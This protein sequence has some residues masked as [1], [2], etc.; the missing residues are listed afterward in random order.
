MSEVEI[1]R[2]KRARRAY[3]LDDIAVVPSRRTRDVQEVTTSWQLDAY[4]L[5]I[6]V[7]SAPMDSVTSPETAIEIGR[8]GGVGVLDLEGLWTR[9][10]DPRP[11]F[12]EIADLDQRSSIARL[13]EI[14]AEPVKEELIT[15]RLNEIRDAGVTVAGALSPGRT[16]E[17]WRT[18]VD[19]GVDIFVIRGTTVSAE[20]VSANRE[21]LNLKRFIYELDVPVLVG[22]A[23]TYTGALHLMR[24]G[25]AGVL[26]GY[27]GGAASANRRTVGIA[28]PMATTIA[29]I[30]A[31]RRDYL[32]ESGGRY[33]HV[34]ADGSV[35]TA[36]DVVKAIACGADGV[37][38]GTA[39]ARADEAPGRGWHWGQEAH[40][41]RLPRG[42]RVQVGTAGPLEQI[43][44]GPSHTA[45]GTTNLMGALR[46][47]MAA[48]GYS[49]VKEFQRAE[50]VVGG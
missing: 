37:M 25:A 24:T 2:A 32:D 34:V 14:Y 21:P 28:A 40:H 47:A 20:H 26:A 8:L 31:A 18:V 23:V 13:Q 41:S 49:D 50:V 38:L 12:E 48:N 11:L 7:L 15:E 46:H 19:A 6:P 39:L 1:G 43:L 16:Q 44:F 36:G 29:D 3:T 5:E 22:G 9:Y 27:G 45:D 10:E 42:D 17:L 35:G 33:V 30:A 4:H